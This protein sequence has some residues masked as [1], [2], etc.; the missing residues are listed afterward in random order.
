[1]LCYHNHHRPTCAATTATKASNVLLSQPLSTN[2]RCH[3]SHQRL[4]C[5]C[6]HSYQ[7]LH[8]S[9]ITAA[10]TASAYRGKVCSSRCLPFAREQ[11]P[12]QRRAKA[13]RH[14]TGQCPTFEVKR[15]LPLRGRKGLGLAGQGNGDGRKWSVLAIRGS[16][17]G[18]KWL[19]LA[20]RGNGDR[21]K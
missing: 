3:R 15:S 13:A 16:S 12:K 18:R 14:L 19:D 5:S 6:N 21:R 1:M 10:A 17:D 7:H 20:G 9:A 8:I 2:L 4:R 11:N